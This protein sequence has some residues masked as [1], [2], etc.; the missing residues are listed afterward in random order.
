MSHKSESNYFR[1]S[2]FPSSSYECRERIN[3]RFPYRSDSFLDEHLHWIPLCVPPNFDDGLDRLCLWRCAVLPVLP[4]RHPW[5]SDLDKCGQRAWHSVPDNSIGRGSV[6]QNK[7]VIN[8]RCIV[9]LDLKHNMHANV[10]YRYLP[11]I[12][13]HGSWQSQ[14]VYGW[15]ILSRGLNRFNVVTSSLPTIKISP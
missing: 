8:W 13:K 15:F 11:L 4:V 5:G 9:E 12:M 1:F 7:S 6:R 2:G 3:R 14:T 10:G